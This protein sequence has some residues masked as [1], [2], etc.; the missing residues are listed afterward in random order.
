[1]IFDKGAEQLVWIKKYY[2]TN[3]VDLIGYPHIKEWSWTCVSHHA[4]RLTKWIK[5]QNIAAKNIKLRKNI[6]ICDLGQE[7]SFFIV[8]QKA[9]ATNE[10]YINWASSTLKIKNMTR[11]HLEYTFYNT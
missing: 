6:N 4:W 3:R 7:N 10:K 9:Q 5:I 11:I 1:M 8:T 2:S